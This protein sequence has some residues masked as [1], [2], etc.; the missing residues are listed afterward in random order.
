MEQ[1]EPPECPVCLQPYDTVSAIP[2]VLTCG[3][4]TCE[5]CIKQLPNPFPNTVRCTV[6]TLL[7]KLP[8]SPSNLPKNLDLLHFSSLLQHR[9]HS[10]KEEKKSL[11]GEKKEQLSLLPLISK[12]WSHEFY[13]K[14]NRWIIP[15]DCIFFIEEEMGSD[16]I[17][18][19]GKVLKSFFESVN[20]GCVLRENEIVGLVKVGVFVENKED[21]ELFRCS[22]ESRIV[23]VLFE[24]KEEGRVELNSILDVNLRVSNVGKVYG[25]WYNE[26][27]SYVYMVCEKF[28]SPKLIQCLLKEKE[29]EEESLS[30]DGMSGL[31]MLGMEMCEILSHLHS[32]GL[33]IGCLGSS[34]FTFNNFGRVY[35]DLSEI[36]N[37]GRTI[38]MAFHCK[39]LELS[40]KKNLL[41]KN[42]VLISPEL[43]LHYIVKEDSELVRGR[44]GYEV[45]CGSDLWSLSC[46]LVWV[47][48]GSSFL[49]EMQTLLHH[50]VDIKSDEKGFDYSGLY[51]IWIEKIEA[52]LRDRLGLEYVS[53]QEILCR[54]LRF[55]PENRP[56]I[57]ELWKC[58]RELVIKPKFDFGVSLDQEVTEENSG[59][60]VVLGELC[61]IV[62][63]TNK[64]FVNGFPGVDENGT[65]D[66]KS[67]VDGDVVEGVSKSRVKCIEMKGHLDC[68]TGLAVGGGFLFSSSYDKIVHVWSLQDFTHVHS[69]KGHEHRVMA[70]VFVEGEQPL[71]ISGDNEGV[72]CIWEVGFPFSKVPVQKLYEQ[73]DWRYSGIHAMAVSGT[74][75]LYTGS[76]D[77]LV[78]AWSLQ[79]NAYNVP[80]P[81]SY[82]S[83]ICG[84]WDGTV[85]LWSLSDHSPLT[86]LGEDQ[87]GN[88]SSILSLSAENQSLLVGHEN[89]GV[90]S[91]CKKGKWF[92]SGGWD[93]TVSVQE[94]S[95]DG[96]GM[97]I[98]PLGSIT[99]NSTI[100]T[101]V[102]WEGKLFVGQADRIVKFDGG[103]ATSICYFY[104]NNYSCFC[105]LHV[106]QAVATPSFCHQFSC[107]KTSGPGFGFLLHKRKKKKKKQQQRWLE[108]ELG[109]RR[110]SHVVTAELSSSLSVNIGLDSQSFYSHDSSH[111]PWVGP[112]P[113]DIAEVEAYCR[114]F[115]A[116][117]RFH[118]ALMD[119]LCNPLTG[120]CTVSYDVPAEDK[121]LLEDKIVSVLGCMVCLLNK[122]REDVLL[123]RSSIVNSFRD[124]DKSSMD[125]S[126][127]PLANFRFEMKSY[128][129]SL[130]VA[131]EN[132]L[133]PGDDRSLKVWRKLQRLK[134]V[135]YDTGFPRMDDHPCQMLFANWSPVYLSTSKE[136]TQSENEVA[137]WKGGQVTEESLKWLLEKGFRT[138]IDLRAETV[139]DVFYETVLNEAI[140][141]GKI[142]LIEL[143]VE[144][145]TAPSMDQVAQFAALVS[146]SR[147]KPVYVHSKEGRRRTSSMI[148]RWRQYVDRISSSNQ[149]VSN[150][151]MLARETRRVEDSQLSLNV[152]QVKSSGNINGSLEQKSNKSYGP[153]GVF[154]N[155]D[156][157]AAE[158]E[159]QIIKG[160]LAANQE[161][162]EFT[163][164]ETESPNDFYEDVKPLES[165]LPP[166]D[167]FSRKE[168]SRFFGNSKISP[169]TYFSYERKRLE[170]VS[171]LRNEHNG[172]VLKKE[173]DSKLS[174]NEEGNLN[175]SLDNKLPSKTQSTAVSNGSHQDLTVLLTPS[176]RLNKTTDSVVY[177]KSTKNGSINTSS[178]LNMIITPK[179]VTEEHRTD[180]ESYPSSDNENMDILEGNMCA[181]ATGVVR[182]QSRKKAEMFLV[183]TDGFS[184]TRE[185]VT[186]SS[187]AFTHPSTQQQMLLWKS[188][189]KTVLL[190]K[191]LGQELM[192][193][194]KEVASF[195]YYQEKMN[196]LVE[197]EVHDVFAR[198]P[199]FGFVQTFYSQDTS[200]LHE[201][202]DLVA[203]LGGD[204]FDDYKNDLRQVIHGNNTTDGIYITLRMRL[205]CEIFRDGKAKTG[206]VFDVLNEIVVDRGS[207]P[208]LSKIECYEHDRLITKVQGD[209]VIV[210]TPTGST[211]YSTAAGGSMVHP[212]VP[213]MLFTPICPH[214]LSFRPVILPDSARLELKIPE[215]ARS[216]AWVSFDG[217]RRQQ[218]SRGDSVR[219]SMSQHP[220]PTVNKSDQTGDWFRSLIRC[221][222]WNERLDQKA[223]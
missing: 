206:K 60:C 223:L 195:L 214:S 56:H 36:I 177:D 133:I 163:G 91:V 62:E 125:D 183:R 173:T 128:C 119:A 145:G 27:D 53:L 109:R 186:E 182:V 166:F 208:Y 194:A 209:G 168:M 51:I 219:I 222:N 181:S 205:R 16:E 92:F 143:P 217:K 41:D 2:R 43:L 19:G 218:L 112:L 77:K 129:E 101:L 220:L 14:W 99:C 144:V 147:K 216:N 61:R 151:D 89:G 104:S 108:P 22:Y 200:D 45:G 29:D 67:R 66:G 95:E 94:I 148:S 26:N 6:C 150:T 193:E 30:I 221:L 213:C 123:G 169:G 102:Y 161:T 68:I 149:R 122:G 54:C 25:V 212:N 132:Y 40:L 11:K 134:N 107:V 17:V 115:R 164:S 1:A 204:G 70:V 117:E 210:A 114:I 192:E 111:L 180:I 141:S 47:L 98:A 199:G 110:F 28:G 96:D 80:Y 49:E 157:S 18:Y 10:I 59:F 42:F 106:N 191:K 33:A 15:E 84:S 38:D 12:S 190:L 83:N 78:K 158:N 35:L 165:Q 135:C 81:S 7:V 156:P 69:F 4:T 75:Y 8:N 58:L 85:R 146:D 90:F 88:I 185:K 116:A 140:L 97:D 130:H 155:Q 103:M 105:H 203:C 79:A 3:H 76:G 174:I 207:N 179:K 44:S 65:G 184:C 176:T 113:G 32:K 159:S 154:D 136:E 55:D 72:I 162:T 137:F 50:V 74:Q 126:L 197:P 124:V 82:I 189:P 21:S 37:M 211:A 5:A 63:E 178:Q 160:A 201:R 215:D 71:C 34:C 172:R 175:G 138:I 39:D 127:P 188:T 20:S 87:L 171:S 187:L 120:E 100:T 64:E 121:S 86:V 152:D 31:W 131:L 202:V 9:H 46:L 118:N 23:S 73:K 196:I 142:E 52:L 198:I 153:P 24:M 13:C 93:K 170:A 139:K 57:T 48:V 167:I